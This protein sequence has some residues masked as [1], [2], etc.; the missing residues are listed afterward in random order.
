[1]PRRDLAPQPLRRPN[2][3]AHPAHPR[4]PAAIGAIIRSASRHTTSARLT[5]GNAS[6]PGAPPSEATN[7][8]GPL[9]QLTLRPTSLTATG[10][11]LPQPPDTRGRGQQAANTDEGGMPRFT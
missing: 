9:H 5:A 11:H 3:R 7:W 4:P 1:M 2:R 8:G 6:Q 10:P